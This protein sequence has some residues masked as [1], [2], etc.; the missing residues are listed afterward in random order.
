VKQKISPKTA[1]PVLYYKHIVNRLKKLDYNYLK[2]T[3]GSTGSGKTNMNISEMYIINP[4]R[5]DASRVTMSPKEYQDAKADSKAGDVIIWGES[6]V[7]LDRRLWYQISQIY[8]TQALMVERKKNL[9]VIFDTPDPSFMDSR[10]MKLTDCYS[11]MVRYG[12]DYATQFL[13]KIARN[14][15]KDITLFPWYSFRYAGKIRHFPKVKVLKGVFNYV[16]RKEPKKVAE[17]L[18]KIDEYKDKVEDKAQREA[19]MI[20]TA[21][22]SEDVGKTIFDWVNQI[23][24]DPEKYRNKKGVL[25]WHLIQAYHPVLS[26]DRSQTIQRI[27]KKEHPTLDSP[28]NKPDKAKKQGKKQRKGRNAHSLQKVK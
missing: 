27:L 28:P 24:K 14:R 12:R 23:A 5:F 7:G 1:M 10:A 18:K 3:C 8:M 15:K 9:C 25:D 26:R 21:R 17:I 19:S 11:E 13:Y 2:M 6:G 16:K 20:E 22:W 4:K